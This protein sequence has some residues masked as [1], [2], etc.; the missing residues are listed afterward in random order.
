MLHNTGVIPGS[1]FST[2]ICKPYVLG[3]LYLTQ[4]SNLDI[5]KKKLKMEK[6]NRKLVNLIIQGK[7]NN[8]GIFIVTERP[9]VVLIDMKLKRKNKVYSSWLNSL[10]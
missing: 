4:A 3:E 6:L 7:T 5:L 10:G 1:W 2:A 9:I 8:F